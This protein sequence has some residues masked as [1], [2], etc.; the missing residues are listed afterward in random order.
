LRNTRISTSRVIVV[1]L[2]ALGGCG[3]PSTTVVENASLD[4]A[5]AS[6]IDGDLRRAEALFN[7]IIE[8]GRADDD[9]RTACLYLG[10]IYLAQEDYERAA[11]VLSAGKALGGDLRFDEYFEIARQHLTA[12]P[13]RIAQLEFITRGQLAA[14]IDRMFGPLLDRSAQTPDSTAAETAVEVQGGET[15]AKRDAVAVVS[16]AGVMPLLADG[17]FRPEERVTGP[18]F[19]AIAAR[20]ADTIR[21]PADA[22]DEM[23]P[24]GYRGTLGPQAAGA[25]G[26]G[27]HFLSGR[28]AVEALEALARRVGS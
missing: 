9:Y 26:G 4:K 12:L 20:L 7:E 13:A 19:F 8:Q 3:P 10:R 21:A 16:R 28:E 27:T 24:A 1:C 18:A 23:F 5:I 17:T 14:L 15:A 22:I 6:Y 2:L 11:E 25:N